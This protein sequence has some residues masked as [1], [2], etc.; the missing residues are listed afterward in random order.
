MAQ[1]FL[2]IG[3]NLGDRAAYLRSAR[4]RLADQLGSIQ[5]TSPIFE[6]AAWGVTNQPSFLNQALSLLTD[7]APSECL[8]RT[9]AIEQQLDR[10]R[11]LH[12][13]PR[14]ID[15]DLLF[16]DQLSL[17]TERLTLP[18]PWLHQRQFVLVPLQ[19]IAADFVHPILGKT[20]TQLQVDCPD[21]SMVQPWCPTMG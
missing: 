7:Y 1:L 15:I 9:Q 12:W 19:S 16:Y 10:E 5:R 14:T 21:E 4:Q 3:S 20:I 17:K 18:H 8:D 13:G 11:L 6:T 2:H